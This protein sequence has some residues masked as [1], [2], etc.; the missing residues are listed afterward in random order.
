MYKYYKKTSIYGMLLL[1][2][3][4]FIKVINQPYGVGANTHVPT[5]NVEGTSNPSPKSSS[6][7]EG[8]A[9]ATPKPQNILE[10]IG[11]FELYG[12]YVDGRKVEENVAINTIKYD[13]GSITEDIISAVRT[14][15]GNQ[16]IFSIISLELLQNGRP[17]SQPAVIKVY[18][19]SKGVFSG[20]ENISLYKIIDNQKVINIATTTENNIIMFETEELGKYV[21]C[22]DKEQIEA[23]TKPLETKKPL[24]EATDAGI[25]TT[26]LPTGMPKEEEA[27]LMSPGAFVFW[28]ILVLIIGLWIGLGIGYI[29]WGR[30]KSKKNYKGPFVIGE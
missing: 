7:L 15:N 1:S 16:D 17:I 29:L 12:E 14:Q 2:L 13:E 4:L 30:Y 9:T 27:G 23:T 26:N 21:V 22:G 19:D 18:I 28:L 3:I 25:I 24:Q 10:S 6:E 8:T 11:D 5:N 20:F